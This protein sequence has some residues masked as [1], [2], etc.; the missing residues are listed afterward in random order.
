MG[1]AYSVEPVDFAHAEEVRRTHGDY[2]AQYLMDRV[3]AALRR[4]DEAEAV[5]MDRALRVVVSCGNGLPYAQG[6]EFP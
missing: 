6:K 5:V 2:A 1:S 4:G 3:V